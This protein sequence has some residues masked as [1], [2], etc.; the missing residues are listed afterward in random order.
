M[1]KSVFGKT[2]LSRLIGELLLGKRWFG[3][4]HIPIRI[5]DAH[6]AKDGV[7]RRLSIRI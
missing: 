6:F 7:N 4:E 5:K 1:M 3:R 2:H